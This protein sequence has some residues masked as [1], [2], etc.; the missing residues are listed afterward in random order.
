MRTFKI[1]FVLMTITSLL[2]CQ[3]LKKEVENLYAG[4]TLKWEKDFSRLHYISAAKESKD[5]VIGEVFEDHTGKISYYNSEGDLLWSVDNLIQDVIKK[6]SAIGTKICD[7][8]D[9]VIVAW[10][11][12]YESG[13]CQIY[14]KSGELLYSD[15]KQGGPPFD[16]VIMSPDGYYNNLKHPLCNKYGEKIDLH[17]PFNVSRSS[18]YGMSGFLSDKYILCGV[19]EYTPEFNKPFKY[20]KENEK[21]AGK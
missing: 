12:D 14:N 15:R 6:V 13:C 2:F 11:G 5:F 16:E 3:S 4:K 18:T 19:D 1:I 8:G 9:V 21:L 20:T 17:L 10:G 7:Y